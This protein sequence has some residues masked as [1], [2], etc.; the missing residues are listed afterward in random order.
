MVARDGL[1]IAPS[2]EFWLN[3]LA[4]LCC[5]ALDKG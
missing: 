4:D 2:T 3:I 1:L 5:G